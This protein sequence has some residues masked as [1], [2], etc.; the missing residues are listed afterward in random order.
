M[1]ERD[2]PKITTPRVENYNYRGHNYWISIEP[3]K[4]D[5]TGNT[6]FLAYKSYEEPGW[7]NNGSLVK[8]FNGDVIIAKEVLVAFTLAN[9]VIQAEID[10][11]TK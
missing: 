4:H 8:D 3:V 7:L 9:A 11:L 10:S 1:L 6:V 5:S 2:T